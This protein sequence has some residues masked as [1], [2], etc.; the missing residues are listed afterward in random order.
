MSNPYLIG[1]A[2]LGAV[3][4]KGRFA[5]TVQRR[6]VRGDESPEELAQA[7][8]GDFGTGAA[9]SVDQGDFGPASG[10]MH[11][12]DSATITAVQKALKSKGFDPGPIDGKFGTKTEDALF[13]FLGVHGPPDDVALV[14]LGVTPGGGGQGAQAPSP[15]TSRSAAPSGG[16][17]SIFSSPSAPSKPAP[18]AAMT[19]FWAQPLW[20]GSPVKRWQGA[21]GGAGLFALT[22]GL[23]FLVRR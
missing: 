19:S 16:Y 14:R 5:P 11:Y 18:M 1:A 23:L 4:K 17:A 8:I 20:E 3:P 12:T 7:V 22:G 15:S 6:R 10:G 9:P 2:V 13:K 21:V